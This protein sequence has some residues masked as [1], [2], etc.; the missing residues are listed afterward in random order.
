MAPLKYYNQVV[1]LLLMDGVDQAE[2]DTNL[3]NFAFVTAMSARGVT[4][5]GKWIHNVQCFVHCIVDKE[6][7][8]I[9]LQRMVLM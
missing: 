7:L 8:V 9:L 6:N 1:P 4:F 3:I 5:L 2:M